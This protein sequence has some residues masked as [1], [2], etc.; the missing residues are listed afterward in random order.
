MKPIV[1]VVDKENN[2]VSVDVNEF[3]KICNDI[4]QQG[5]DDGYKAGRDSYYWYCSSP[6]ITYDKIITTTPGT[7]GDKK[8]WDDISI[9]CQSNMTA[10][11]T[12]LHNMPIESNDYIKAYN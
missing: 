7:T 3:K 8:W 6:T 1:V 10:A 11:D 9:T 5:Y 12:I 2:K 4:Y